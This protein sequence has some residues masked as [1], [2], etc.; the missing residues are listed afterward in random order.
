MYTYYKVKILQGL[1]INK[2]LEIQSFSFSPYLYYS[3]DNSLLRCIDYNLEYL[4]QIIHTIDLFNIN[5]AEYIAAMD[6]YKKFYI[7]LKVFF[8]LLVKAQFV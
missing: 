3:I 1:K 4:R 7:N 8:L 5:S 2:K 6:K